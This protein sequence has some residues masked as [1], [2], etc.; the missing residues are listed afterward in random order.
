MFEVFLCVSICSCLCY[1]SVPFFGCCLDPRQVGSL[2]KCCCRSGRQVTQRNGDRRKAK[3]GLW[4]RA[5]VS[6]ATK[7]GIPSEWNRYGRGSWKQA[8]MTKSK[9]GESI[10]GRLVRITYLNSSP[11][12]PPGVPGGRHFWGLAAD[13]KGWR[14]AR[15]RSWK[16]GE[17]RAK[18]CLTK[19]SNHFFLH[20]SSYPFKVSILS[21]ITAIL[22]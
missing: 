11:V 21:W 19:S 7:S 14:W 12:Y 18:V 10:T 16:E 8:A 17:W 5:R 1:M 6:Q 9:S 2:K 4:E 22:Y 3:R 15:R 13:T 20:H